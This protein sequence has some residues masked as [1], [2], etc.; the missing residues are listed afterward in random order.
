M[1]C[2]LS[3]RVLMV[4]PIRYGYHC[5][6]VN[7]H[8]TQDANSAMDSM[9]GSSGGGA[10]GYTK[11]CTMSYNTMGCSSSICRAKMGCSIRPMSCSMMDTKEMIG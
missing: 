11:G 3:V 4:H 9:M 7:W 6:S 5:L 10:K 1:S 2:C 8:N